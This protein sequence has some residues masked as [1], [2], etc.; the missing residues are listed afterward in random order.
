LVDLA[1][2][3]PTCLRLQ[4]RDQQ[5]RVSLSGSSFYE[6]MHEELTILGPDPIF[7]LAFHRVAA[8]I[9]GQETVH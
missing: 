1:Q 5:R 4:T 9:E 6:L 2:T 3:G 7:D 8:S